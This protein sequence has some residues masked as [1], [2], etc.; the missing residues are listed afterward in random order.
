MH[1]LW[2]DPPV[3]HQSAVEG[4][5]SRAQ[6][7]ID[8]G[9]LPA[10]Q[11]ALAVDGSVVVDVT[12]GAAP[13]DARFTVFSITKGYLA[14]GVWLLVGEG[15]LAA[16]T[17]VVD[18]IPEFGTNGK[19][20]VTL[21]HLLTHT[22]GFARAP[23]R[24]EDGATSAGRVARF[25]TWTLDWP[26]GSQ[27]EY[28]G[29]SAHWVVAELIERVTGTD[30]RRFLA[31]QVAAPLG[32]QRLQLGVP[33]HEGGDVATI[34][35]MDETGGDFGIAEATGD[36]LVRYNEP[37]VRAVGVPGSGAVSTAADVAMLYQALMRNDPPLWDPAVL[38]DGTGRVRTS[39]V[40]PLRGV[41]ANRTLGMTVAGDDGN[42]PMRDFG[43]A[44]SPRA[45]GASGLGGQVAWADPE[46][47]LS[48]CWLT[49]G[50]STDIVATYRRSVGLS[51][52]AAQCVVPE[53]SG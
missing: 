52:R 45:F 34:V 38:A 26:P 30:Y 36:T 10:G 8:N 9:R 6:H 37:A 1:R 44:N 48:F 20:V 19:D 51:T 5:I 49:N 32:L 31:E 46:T 41:P 17:R 12:L 3:P 18:L 21:E 33:P 29:T 27:L 4:L 28:H 50:L 11:L 42:A 43:K 2:H 39:Y 47:G 13:A 14:A 7:D 53:V 25:A 15:L 16:E 40:D 24:P 22:A 23:M 35:M